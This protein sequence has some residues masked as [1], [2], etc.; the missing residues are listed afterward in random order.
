MSQQVLLII[1]IYIAL[2]CPAQAGIDFHAPR[3]RSAV[4]TG[5]IEKIGKNFIEILDEDDGLIK[6][7]TFLSA[8]KD[9]KVGERVRVYYNTRFTLAEMIKKM[10]PVQYQE[11]GQNAGYIYKADATP[12]DSGGEGR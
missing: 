7:V 3:A 4:M 2:I 9:F 1:M 12:D 6:R 11:Q 8:N 5:L 10:T